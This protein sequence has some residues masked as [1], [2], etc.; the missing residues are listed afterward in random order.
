M[1]ALHEAAASGSLLEQIKK[2]ERSAIVHIAQKPR[3]REAE[4]RMMLMEHV[5]KCCK[6]DGALLCPDGALMRGL[7]ERAA[8]RDRHLYLSREE[9][10]IAPES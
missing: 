9:K 5:A 6:C 8:E 2:E 10:P 4:V 7:E 3:F 1:D